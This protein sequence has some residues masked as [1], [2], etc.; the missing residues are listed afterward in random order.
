MEKINNIVI[1]DISRFVGSSASRAKKKKKQATTI[2]PFTE[3]LEE[4]Q[5]LVPNSA[6]PSKFLYDIFSIFFPGCI[7][8]RDGGGTDQ[9]DVF[10]SFSVGLPPPPRP[11][12]LPRLVSCV[13]I[14][15]QLALGEDQN[16][17]ELQ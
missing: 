14:L 1:P 12:L 16:E 3:L 17:E 15:P 2:F 9:P 11:A 5:E 6:L 7:G 8:R 10:R 4:L 13:Q